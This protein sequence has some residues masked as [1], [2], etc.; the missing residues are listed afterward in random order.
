MG[1]DDWWLFEKLLKLEKEFDVKAVYNFYADERPKNLR[2]WLMDP[3]YEIS[4]HRI[5]ALLLEIK[6]AGHDIGLHSSFDSWNKAKNLKEQKL[7]IENSL[8]SEVSS[9]RQ[10][11]LRFG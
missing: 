3:S 1:F 10:H 7:L 11:W 6:K 8:G 5:K 2:R 4:S 9:C